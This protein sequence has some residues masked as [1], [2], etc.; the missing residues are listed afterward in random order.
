VE[1]ALCHRARLLS[2]GRQT[3][4]VSLKMRAMGDLRGFYGALEKNFLGRVCSNF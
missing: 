3:M 1:Q 2:A 4:R